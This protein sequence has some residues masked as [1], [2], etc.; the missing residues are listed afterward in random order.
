V[1]RDL[2]QND[3]RLAALAAIGLLWGALLV[4]IGFAFF[5]VVAVIGGLLLAA[6][7]ALQG[8]SLVAAIEPRL[9]RARGQ[10]RVAIGATS[11][12]VGRADW[13][14]KRKAL[15]RRASTVG[16]LAATGSRRAIAAGGT[17]AAAVESRRR[18][19]AAKHTA[20]PAQP[21]R[22]DALRLNEQA[23]ILRSEQRYGEALE[24]SEQALA[25]YRRLDDPHG[26][27]LTLNGLGLTQARAGDE[28]GALDSY[29]TAVAL[30]N[31]IGDSHGAGR[32]L[33]NLGVLHRGQGHDA[34]ARAAWSEALE[35]FEP[36]TPEHDRMAQQLKLAS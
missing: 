34:Q 21:G 32:V 31:Q 23:A 28:A 14:T 18:E 35:R 8:R 12:R 26:T 17:A 22:S 15:G 33:A 3:R 7:A 9:R 29:E 4:A 1:S 2:S 19:L 10:L 24:L 6:T 16:Q 5:F 36:G 20:A 13:S 27:A 11:A 25:I 30:L